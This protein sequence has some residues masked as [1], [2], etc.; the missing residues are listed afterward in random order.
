VKEAAARQQTGRLS[1]LLPVEPRLPEPQLYVIPAEVRIPEPVLVAGD[2]HIPFHDRYVVD[3]LL[4][5]AERDGI[6]HLVLNG[7]V[8]SQDVFLHGGFDRN[9]DMPPFEDEMYE[10]EQ[11]FAVLAQ[12]F[13]RLTVVPGNH[14]RRLLKLAFGEVTLE[15][16]YRMILAG[17]PEGLQSTERDYVVVEADGA[18]DWRVTHGDGGGSVRSA[19]VAPMQKALIYQQNVL[20]GHSHLLGYAPTPDGRFVGASGGCIVDETRLEYKQTR[21]VTFPRWTQGFS[22][23]IDG[24]LDLYSRD[25]TN[26]RR[27]LGRNLK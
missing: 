1:D 26:W 25:Y 17:P 24:Y 13:K 6:E 21:T 9:P 14:E 3:A 15:R 19:I 22:T 20:Q 8:M 11:V 2:W 4:A 7:D 27:E 18:T 23:L 5:I 10:T 16:L 12:V